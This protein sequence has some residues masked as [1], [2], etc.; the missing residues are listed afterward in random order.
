MG[1]CRRSSIWEIAIKQ[2]LGRRDTPISGTR[3]AELCALAGYH[4]LPVTWRQ[5]AGVDAY[6]MR[7]TPFHAKVG[8]GVTL[9]GFPDAGMPDVARHRADEKRHFQV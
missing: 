9:P 7:S 4:D 6:C 2:A 8:A 5:A 1:V 3:A